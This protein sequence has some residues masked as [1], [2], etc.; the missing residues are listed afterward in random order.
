MIK[1]FKTA[2]LAAAASAGML[3]SVPASAVPAYEPAR[4]TAAQTG[5][6]SYNQYRHRYNR[7]Y[8]GSRYYGQP[9]YQSNRVWRG[10]DGRYYCRR[11]NGTTGLIIG[12]AAGALLGRSLD[13]GYNRSTGTILGGAAG[14][15]LGRSVARN[16]RCR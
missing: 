12:G 15:L 3:A 6:D 14:A 10:R 5:V 1:L 13:G 4:P 8:R 9:V 7:D 11:G 2:A 16:S